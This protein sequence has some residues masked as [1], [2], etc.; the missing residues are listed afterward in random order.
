MKGL[1]TE[2]SHFLFDNEKSTIAISSYIER[3]S[4]WTG[5]P[6]Y[7]INAY[8]LLIFDNQSG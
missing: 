4:I 2:T 6:C 1:V 5:L 3:I 8:F 7:I